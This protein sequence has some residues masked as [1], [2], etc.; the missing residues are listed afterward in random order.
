M[1]D[2]QKNF[3]IAVVQTL[4]ILFDKDATMKKTLSF[5]EKVGKEEVQ[6]I[7][8]PEAFI[9]SYFRELSFGYVIRSRITE[10]RKD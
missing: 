1:K 9:S 4:P 3:K 6:L 8:F 2:Y 5:I 10:G 7:I